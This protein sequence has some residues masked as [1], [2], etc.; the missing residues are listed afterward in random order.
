[1]FILAAYETSQQSIAEA[2][3]KLKELLQDEALIHISTNDDTRRSAC[4][5]TKFWTDW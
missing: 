4:L 5:E 1:M 3:T 2:H